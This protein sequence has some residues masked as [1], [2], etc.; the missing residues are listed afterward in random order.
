MM[1]LAVKIHKNVQIHYDVSLLNTSNNYF[2]MFSPVGLKRNYF[3]NEMSSAVRC[4]LPIKKN[5]TYIVPAACLIEIGKRALRFALL[6][7]FSF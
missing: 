7:L 2:E 1:L 3:M 6:P 4:M 5:R